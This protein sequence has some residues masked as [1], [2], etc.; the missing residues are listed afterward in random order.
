M[1]LIFDTWNKNMTKAIGIQDLNKDMILTLIQQLQPDVNAIKD[2]FQCKIVNDKEL[3]LNTLYD[4]VYM[5]NN[6]VE[7][8]GYFSILNE[9][10]WIDIK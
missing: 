8:I 10:G 5:N 9:S 2:H 7:F 1:L 6:D 4:A 3:K